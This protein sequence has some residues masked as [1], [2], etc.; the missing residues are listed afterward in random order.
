MNKV[1][2]AAFETVPFIK[3]GGLADVAFSLPKELRQLG[4]D[5]RV[6]LPK[7]SQ[8]PERFKEK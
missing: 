2:Y 4:T 5:V 7:Y 1:L 8:I 6:V 3:S